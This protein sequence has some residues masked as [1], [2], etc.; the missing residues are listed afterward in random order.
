MAAGSAKA[1]LLLEAQTDQ[2]V[3]RA[4]SAAASSVRTAFSAD[5]R[6]LLANWRTAEGSQVDVWQI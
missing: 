2:E 4:D 3:F 1:V 5:G 6:H